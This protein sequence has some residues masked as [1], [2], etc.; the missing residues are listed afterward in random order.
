[1]NGLPEKLDTLQAIELAEGVEIRLRIAGPI[2]RMWA[3][4]LDVIF[5]GLAMIGLSMVGGITGF[6]VG[7][8]VV[9]GM[10]KLSWFLLF[11]WYPV[12]FEASRRGATI[13]KRI[14]GLRVIHPSGAPI[15]FSQAVVRNFIR[16]IDIMPWFSGLFGLTSCLSTRRFQRL[17][18]LAAGTV[19]VY[20]RNDVVPESVGPP[21]L[22]PQRPVV[23][24]NAEE[25]LALITFRERSVYWSDARRAEIADH[26]QALTNSTGVAG[27][28]KLMA[29]AHWLQEKR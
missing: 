10:M 29:M 26:L 15:S 12:F 7:G 9:G 11:W 5:I 28:T 14:C 23:A 22:Q 13:G 24:L 8:Q 4:L 1:M 17:G 21:P 18:D 20:E 6:L 19:V 3:W 27:V 16:V 2:L 25:A